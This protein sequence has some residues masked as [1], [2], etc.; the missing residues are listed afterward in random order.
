M[1]KEYNRK[2]S[3]QKV[4]RFP[5][6]LYKRLTN[7]RPKNGSFSAKVIDLVMKGESSE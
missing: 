4:I 1:K 3:V 5:S 2:H 7:R 6:D